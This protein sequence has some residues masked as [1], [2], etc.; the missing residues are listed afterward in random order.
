MS[1]FESRIL[2][3]RA[4]NT[5]RQLSHNEMLVT[6]GYKELPPKA[7]EYFIPNDELREFLPPQFHYLLFRKFLLKHLYMTVPLETATHQ[8]LVSH[9]SGRTL[10]GIIN[11]PFVPLANKFMA[12]KFDL[13]GAFRSGGV[14][15]REFELHEYSQTPFGFIDENHVTHVKDVSNQL[16]KAGLRTSVVLGGVVL[17]NDVVI[18]WLSKQNFPQIIL[19]RAIRDIENISINNKKLAMYWRLGGVSTRWRRDVAGAHDMLLT[20]GD[21]LLKEQYMRNSFTRAAHLFLAEWKAFPEQTNKYLANPNDA[22]ETLESL[23]ALAL[24][25]ELTVDQFE[26]IKKYYAGMLVDYIE[27]LLNLHING[28]ALTSLFNLDIFTDIDLSL[29]Q[30]DLELL[31]LT[32]PDELKILLGQLNQFIIRFSN[33]LDNDLN[34]YSETLGIKQT[35]RT[36]TV[37]RTAINLFENTIRTHV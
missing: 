3:K 33:K 32:R 18:E 26:L 35:T 37:S 13:K 8:K 21:Y 29:F 6:V 30:Y 9:E 10:E 24:R 16:I 5:E 31:N 25:Q 14:Y 19:E 7:I 34:S 2:H 4:R 27:A 23:R 17:K 28:K 20:K 15:Q 1:E 22:D 11:G 12:S 36:S